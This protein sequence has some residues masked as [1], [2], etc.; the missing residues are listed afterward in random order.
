MI[1]WAYCLLCFTL[2]F[3][4]FYLR[5]RRSTRDSAAFWSF[6]GVIHSVV[7]LASG[8]TIFKGHAVWLNIQLSQLST[9]KLAIFIL[10]RLIPFEGSEGLFLHGF[11]PNRLAVQSVYRGYTSLH[12]YYLASQLRT[13]G[14]INSI[15]AE[16]AR[17]FESY[18]IIYLGFGFN[19][20]MTRLI[21]IF[22]LVGQIRCLRRYSA[23]ESPNHKFHFQYQTKRT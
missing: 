21:Y 22:D 10:T 3:P 9:S 2:W 18:T 17:E 7:S 8:C 11:Y 15:W 16:N 19:A 6:S 14:S 4:G 20:C 12:I 23:T 13:S 1:R 5:S